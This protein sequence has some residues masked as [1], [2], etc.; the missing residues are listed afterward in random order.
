LRKQLQRLLDERVKQCVSNSKVTESTCSKI[1]AKKES[2]SKRSAEIVKAKAAGNI[3]NKATNED[4]TNV[5]YQVH[6]QYLIKQK[7]HLY[8]EEEIELRKADFYQGTL[9]K[10]MEVN[11]FEYSQEKTV[12]NI[13]TTHEELRQ[14]FQYDRLKAVQYAERWWNSY[15]PAFKKFEENDCTNYI[16]QCLYA[17]GAPMRGYPKRGHGW[18]IRGNNWSWSWPIAHAF[19]LYLGSSKTGLRARE[20][21]RPDQLMLGDVICYDFEGDGRFNHNTIVTGWDY[22]GMPLVNAHTTN[23]RLRYWSYTDSTAYTPNIKYK[24]FTIVDDE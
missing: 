1:E 15:N 11:Q 14:N 3:L 19:S 13:E 8:M 7:N 10:D 21:S 4:T 16:S 9:I 12:P 22:Y 24:F 5:T 6:F 17:G 2:A 23:S 18:W 20:V